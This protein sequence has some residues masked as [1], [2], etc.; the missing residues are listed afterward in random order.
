MDAYTLTIN[1]NFSTDLKWVRPFLDNGENLI[2]SGLLH[3][4]FEEMGERVGMIRH[5]PFS[6]LFFGH[7]A[8]AEFGCPPE[9]TLAKAD[10]WTHL[11][12]GK[13]Q[14]R[15]YEII[16]QMLYGRLVGKE[17]LW[18]AVDGEDVR[19]MKHLPL[20]QEPV[21]ISSDTASPKKAYAFARWGELVEKIR[22]VTDLPVVQLGEPNSKKIPGTY[23]FC[24]KLSAKETIHLLRHS[25][26][27]IC[28]DSFLLH[29]SALAGT[30]T[31]G[32]WGP[33]TP[34]VFGYEEQINITA[35]LPC[36]GHCLQ[37][38]RDANYGEA[39]E[40][41]AFCMNQISVDTIFKTFEDKALPGL[42]L[43]PLQWKDP[44]SC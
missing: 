27:S 29:A 44:E 8:V 10:F 15:P 2:L 31:I 17:K 20:K 26:L 4:A 9:I 13:K 21:V 1:K 24:G 3:N 18:L 38:Q 28:L 39:C 30:P 37:G 41:V 19:E 42:Q 11:Q 35:E 34:E 23:S 22:S 32:L 43:R 40:E 6:T 14:Q 33:T 16:S 36:D 12:P 25:Q 7:P 5:H